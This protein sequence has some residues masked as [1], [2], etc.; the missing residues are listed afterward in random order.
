[1]AKFNLLIKYFPIAYNVSTRLFDAMGRLNKKNNNFYKRFEDEMAKFT[2]L[3]SNIPI[4]YNVFTRL[5]DGL[6]LSL[7]SSLKTMDWIDNKQLTS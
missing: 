3:I 4:A 7:F 6:F 2:L 5:F 1:M